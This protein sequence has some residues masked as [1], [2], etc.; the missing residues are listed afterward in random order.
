MSNFT[1]PLTESSLGI[2]MTVPGTNRAPGPLARPVPMAM[3]SPMVK[4][5]SVP[6]GLVIRPRAPFFS[7]SKASKAAVTVN[8]VSR[9]TLPNSLTVD[10]AFRPA[11]R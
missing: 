3:G 8:R 11:A 4:V 7:T 2:I 1:T 6:T 5:T 9:L 10:S